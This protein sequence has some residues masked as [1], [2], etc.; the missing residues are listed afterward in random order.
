VAGDARVV[1]LLLGA[2]ALVA[3]RG[4]GPV[5]FVP[6]AALIGA[7]ALEAA[8]KIVLD[9]PG[10][11]PGVSRGLSL[12]E[13]FRSSAP[14]FTNAFPSGHALRATLLLGL[15]IGGRAALTAAAAV[16]AAAMWASRLYAGEHW[17]SDVAGGIA[18]GI[19][20]AALVRGASVRVR[21]R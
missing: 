1:A 19:A 5:A 14:H 18:L 4:R 3:L 12:P 16:F 2:L 6:L 7:T 10:P 8:L 20:A 13:W 9:H 21:G 15:V 17:L 11:P